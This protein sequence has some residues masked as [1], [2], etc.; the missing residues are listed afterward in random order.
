M[1]TVE[2][3][4]IVNWSPRHLTGS[5]IRY[6][7]DFP[8]ERLGDVLVR[9]KDKVRIQP[10]VEYTR[11][12]LKTNFGG[13]LLRD[14][15]K[16]D[17]IGRK[18]QYRIK[19][20]QLLVSKID[21][22][23]GAVGIVPQMLNGA[24]VTEN[25]WVY[26]VLDSQKVL[27]DYVALLL[28]TSAFMSLASENSNGSTGRQYMQEKTFLDQ[29]IPV[30]D[31]A[32]QR[33]LVKEYKRVEKRCSYMS[34]KAHQ[35]EMELNKKL[36]EFLGLHQTNEQLSSGQL[37]IY[38]SADLNEWSFDKLKTE[39]IWESCKYRKVRIGEH[40]DI[41]TLVQRGISPQYA[42]ISGTELLNQKCVRWYTLDLQYM[43]NV[44]ESSLLKHPCEVFTKRGDIL[45]NS[46]GD[47]TIGRSAV[48]RKKSECHLLYDSHV[49]MLRVSKDVIDA[50]YLCLLFNSPYVQGQI[51][52][53]K[54]AVATSQTELGVDNLRRVQIILPSL[55]EQ[56]AA[57][58]TLTR[59]RRRIPSQET[60]DNIRKNARISFEQ[61]IIINEDEDKKHIHQ[62]V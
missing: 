4:D 51:E 60:I 54:S 39:S 19:S 24:V 11:V 13:I 33:S 50:E 34:S 1:R 31:I 35:M 5:G 47:G 6:R 2:Y 27:L 56:K 45:I 25:F 40:P 17:A 23:R 30:P 38:N 28:T 46:T 26:D 43:K 59:I 62:I 18:L 15:K 32:V 49:L 57:A 52:Q 41:F 36:F 20:G 29:Y 48:V 9:Q 58:K 22:S 12:T 21:V 42:T 3:K 10:D 7:N 8:L 37:H 55:Q 53:L 61:T 14:K 44:T 16:G